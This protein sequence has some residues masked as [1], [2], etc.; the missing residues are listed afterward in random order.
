MYATRTLPFLVRKL[1]AATIARYTDDY[2]CRIESGSPNMPSGP[3]TYTVGSPI[4]SFPPRDTWHKGLMPGVSISV[5]D[6]D[7]D[8]DIVT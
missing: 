2:H 6:I 3:A 8:I 5:I 7:I 4:R 1:D